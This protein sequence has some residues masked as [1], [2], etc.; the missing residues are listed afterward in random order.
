MAELASG[1]GVF[2]ADIPIDVFETVRSKIAE[3]K[4]I[5]PQ[6]LK[7]ETNLVLDLHAD[8]LDMAEMKSSIQAIFSS[9]SNPP[10]AR[11]KT[12]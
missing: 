11:I 8:S 3:I 9:S 6:N 7:F 12:I 5:D 1:S 4:K 10:I 2:E